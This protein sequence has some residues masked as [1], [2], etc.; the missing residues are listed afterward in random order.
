MIDCREGHDNPLDGFIIEEGAVP[1]A[2]SCLLQTMLHLMPGAEGPENEGII[3]R[4]QAAL[5]HYGSRILG[6]YFKNGAVERTQVYL[7][8]SHDSKTIRPASSSPQAIVG[9]DPHPFQPQVTRP[10]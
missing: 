9:T 1:Q 4:T 8:M 6:P 2:L 7:I 5:A 10:F 3:H